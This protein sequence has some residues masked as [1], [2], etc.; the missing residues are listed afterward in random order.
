MNKHDLQ[1]Q[2][3]STKLKLTIVEIE[4]EFDKPKFLILFIYTLYPLLI[5]YQTT[6]LKN[7]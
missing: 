3:H 1:V 5:Y 6:N 7:I 4:L 2:L